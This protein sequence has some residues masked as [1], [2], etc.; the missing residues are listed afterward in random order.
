MKEKIVEQI[1]SLGL[2]TGERCAVDEVRLNKIAEI[3]SIFNGVENIEAE[4]ILNDTK[5]II[6]KIAAKLPLDFNN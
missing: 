1:K 4:N 3:L 6:K 5:Y 2:F